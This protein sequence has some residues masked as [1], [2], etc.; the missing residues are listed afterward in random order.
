M[1]TPAAAIDKIQ[2]L[3]DRHPCWMIRP[4]GQELQYSIVSVRR[5]LAQIGYFSSFTHNGRWYTLA[6]IPRFSREGLWFHKDIGFSSAGSLTATLVALT[7][8]SPCGLSA[9]ALGQKLHCRCHSVLVHLVRQGRLQ[10]Q[11]VGRHHVYLAADA[12]TATTQLQAAKPVEPS[13][14]PAEIAVLVLAEFIRRPQVAPKQLAKAVS[15]KT[16]LC[17][18]EAQVRAL[19]E[20]HG[21]K[22]TLLP[23]SGF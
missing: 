16:G 17:I 19:F 11:R 21:L 7:E 13:A 22:K 15:A 14:M 9:E 4:L 2:A 5:F 10:R 18:E 23:P 1:A 12:P 3:F 6:S 8:A 20:R